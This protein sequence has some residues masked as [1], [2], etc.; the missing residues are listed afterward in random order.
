[1]KYIIEKHINSYK[2]NILDILLEIERTSDTRLFQL[3]DEMIY[4]LSHNISEQSKKI[5]QYPTYGDDG[6]ASEVRIVL[7]IKF[8]SL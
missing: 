6:M 3:K 2:E 5:I 4:S 1:M 7:N 8:K